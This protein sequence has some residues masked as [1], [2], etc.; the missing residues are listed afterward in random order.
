MEPLHPLSL[1][2]KHDLQLPMIS[3][4]KE[5]T[6][7]ETIGDGNGTRLFEILYRLKQQY[8]YLY[9]KLI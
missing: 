5:H 8:G 1:S 6:A 9:S 2:N 3:F 4:L 7:W